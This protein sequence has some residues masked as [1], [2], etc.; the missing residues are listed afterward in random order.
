MADINHVVLVGRLTRDAELKY[1]NTGTPVCKISLAVNRRRK[2]D[3]QWTEE[4]NFFDVVIWGKM[5]EAIAQYL[6]K[7]K[8]VGIE[9]ELRQNK[10]E[11]DGQPRSKVEIIANNVQLLGSKGGSG[12]G[13]GNKEA[14]AAGFSGPQ[15]KDDFEDDIPF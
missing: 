2:V 8:Q 12:S 15:Q 14:P 3:E 11:Q 5:G 7:G 10:W 9:G 1:T 6:V 13:G 4:A